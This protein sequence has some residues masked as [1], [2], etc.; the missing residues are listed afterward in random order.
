VRAAIPV[1]ILE[2]NREGNRLIVSR[3]AAEDE[4]RRARKRRGA[5]SRLQMGVTQFGG[6]GGKGQPVLRQ[7][8]YIGPSSTSVRGRG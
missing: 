6:G 2:V 7:S 1:K 4:D 5:L 3:R 8:P